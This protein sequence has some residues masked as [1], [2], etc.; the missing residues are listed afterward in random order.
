MDR[1]AIAFILFQ[2]SIA[3]GVVEMIAE[4]TSHHGIGIELG[5]RL[6]ERFRQR[7]DDATRRR[8]ALLESVAGNWEGRSKAYL[9]FSQVCCT[10]LGMIFCRPPY[11]ISLSAWLAVYTALLFVSLIL[12]DRNM[13]ASVPV[14]I[15]VGLAPMIAAFGILNVVMREYRISDELAQ[16][17]TAEGIMFAFGATAILTFSYGFL[18]RTVGAPDISYFWVWA[19]LGST[20][21]LGNLI[22]RQR[23]K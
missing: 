13:I 15:V 20:W 22:A 16:R 21:L 8:R 12:I 23:Y 2:L 18:Q 4:R 14:R 17:I 5:D 19:V 11:L 6:A 3:E 10:V 7:A 1:A 9:T